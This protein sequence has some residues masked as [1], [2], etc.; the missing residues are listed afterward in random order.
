MA[1]HLRSR[2]CAALRCT[3]LRNTAP[4]RT[5]PHRTN[6]SAAHVRLQSLMT[7]AL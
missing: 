2:G 3:A 6:S 7:T 5:A 1:S 4:H